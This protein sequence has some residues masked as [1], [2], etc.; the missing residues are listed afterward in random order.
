MRDLPGDGSETE[1][2]RF[3]AGTQRPLINLNGNIDHDDQNSHKGKRIGGVVIFDW[4][5]RLPI[6]KRGHGKHSVLR[7][8][9]RTGPESSHQ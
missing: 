2:E 8:H 7:L 3:S 9:S 4:N 5:H 1:N 6:L